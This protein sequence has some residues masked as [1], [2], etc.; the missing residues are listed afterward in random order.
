MR[1]RQLS[2]HRASGYFNFIS[3]LPLHFM[4]LSWLLNPSESQLTLKYVKTTLISQISSTVQVHT[5]STM[6]FVGM[7]KP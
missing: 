2:M 5:G 7:K 3:P 4:T 6:L 1:R